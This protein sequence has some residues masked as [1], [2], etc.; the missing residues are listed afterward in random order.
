MVI[1]CFANNLVNLEEN[2]NKLYKEAKVPFTYKRE[3][4]GGQGACSRMLFVYKALKILNNAHVE[5]QA[6]IHFRI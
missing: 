3:G 4:G 5:S 2:L 6:K 1:F